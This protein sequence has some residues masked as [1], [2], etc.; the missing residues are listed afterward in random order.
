M[1]EIWN[2]P[3]SDGWLRAR[4]GRVTG[5]QMGKVCSFMQ[6]N[7]A[8]KKAGDSSAKRDE[9]RRAVIGERLTGVL[10][11]HWESDYMA[12][13][14]DE[15]SHS[16]VAFERLA[17]VMV[18]PVSFVINLEFPWWGATAD[19]L[20]G[21]EGILEMKNPET[22]NHLAYW[23]EGLLPEK[24]T[25]QCATEMACSPMGKKCR[26]ADFFS[27]D[28]R[29]LDPKFQSF[30]VRTGRDEL[31]WEV[32]TAKEPRKLTGEAVID[33][34]TEQAIRFN[35]EVEHFI[36][37]GS[38]PAIAP[39]SPRLK[40]DETTKD[41]PAEDQA[42]PSDFSGDAYRFLDENLAGVP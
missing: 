38:I 7:R 22:A 1:P 27:Y 29:I 31:E 36:A 35:A 30:W 12:R 9:Y 6:V 24:Y 33:Y 42:D 19:G 20:V 18:L 32:G 17:K 34:F 15:E 41:E 23:E 40:E 16:L 26:F 4:C 10:A 2:L 14:N 5:S 11:S 8:P 37:Q 25:P 13:G 39:F 3:Q 21:T 28:R